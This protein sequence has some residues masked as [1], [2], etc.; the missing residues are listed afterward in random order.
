MR[1][2]VKWK[3]L[4][5]KNCQR[6]LGWNKN[7]GINNYNKFKSYTWFDIKFLDQ[8]C[9]IISHFK[10]GILR[11]ITGALFWCVVCMILQFLPF[12]FIRVCFLFEK[13]SVLQ[14]YLMNACKCY[15]RLLVRAPILVKSIEHFCHSAEFDIEMYR[16]INC[17]DVLAIY[18]NIINYK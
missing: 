14:S 16:F 3:W 4:W 15:I 13:F 2:D 1:N 18:I 5:D 10:E 7:F 8:F 9:T 11:H 17:Y 12:C 6:I